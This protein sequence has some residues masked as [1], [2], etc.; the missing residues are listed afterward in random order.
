MKLHFAYGS[1]M[2]RPHM[3]VR[4]PQAVALGTAILEGWRFVIASDGYA[5]IVRE[6]GSR[7]HGVLWRLS[8][9]DLAALNVYENIQGGLYRMR[10]LTVRRQWAPNAYPDGSA[11]HSRHGARDVAALVYIARGEN[12]TARPGYMDLV[13][14]AAREWNL[15]ETY[16]RAL[17]RWAPARLRGAFAPEPGEAA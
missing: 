17:A 14:A 6:R 11:A 3:A 13:V 5:S 10:T 9:R 4:C 15:P 16:L 12:G 8:P 2:S 1:N 7:V